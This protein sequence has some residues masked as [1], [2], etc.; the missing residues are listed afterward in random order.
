MFMNFR[1]AQ[2]FHQAQKIL[3]ACL[4]ILLAAGMAHA[5]EKDFAPKVCI[6]ADNPIDGLNDDE[7]IDVDA[8][9]NYAMAIEKLLSESRFKELDCLADSVRAA[10]I[11][12]GTG[13]W[14]LHI[15]YQ[16][17]STP[18]YHATQKDW[19]ARLSTLQKWVSQWPASATA[20]IAL[21]ETYINYGLDA[22]GEDP[23]NASPNGLKLFTLRVGNARRILEHDAT[24]KAKCPEWYDAMQQIAH[25]QSWNRVAAHALLENAIAFEPTYYSYYRSFAYFLQPKQFGKP[26]DSESFAK[27]IAD[28]IGGDDGDVVYAEAVS[29]IA[30]LCNEEPQLDK[31]SWPRTQKGFALLE[32][33]YGVSLYS[34]NRLAMLA[35]RMHDPVAADKIFSRLGDNWTEEIWLSENNFK[36]SKEWASNIAPTAAHDRALADEAK[37]NFESLGG[38]EYEAAVEKSLMPLIQECKQTTPPPL[39]KFSMYLWIDKEG[40]IKNLMTDYS[41]NNAAPTCLYLKLAA[42]YKANA[43]PFPIPSKASYLLKMEIDLN[44][45]TPIA[46]N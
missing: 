46:A 31:L 44:A 34:M 37:S 45:D 36:I 15:L 10:K 17:L 39:T 8:S 27:E 21:A 22:R 42:L 13:L 5:A 9:K 38:A 14:K 35:W 41:G 7:S 16:G 4:L 33:R 28:R 25:A 26:G 43:K 1:M 32:S 30:C 3:C 2:F 18:Q 29:Q 40:G 23:K 19:Q 11:H 24:L 20:Q 6:V 12:T